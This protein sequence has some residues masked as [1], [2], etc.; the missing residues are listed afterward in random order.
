MAALSEFTVVYAH[1]LF[2]EVEQQKA[3]HFE[4]SENL[5]DDERA[6]QAILI[7][8]LACEEMREIHGFDLVFY[9]DVAWT[10]ILILTIGALLLQS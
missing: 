8:S 3:G 7:H 2:S 9:A 6:K 5:E 10:G 1:Y 4:D